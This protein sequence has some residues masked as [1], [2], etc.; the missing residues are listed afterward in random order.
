MMRS[1][2]L[3]NNLN[4]L[5]DEVRRVEEKV[6]LEYR[7][8]RST[9]DDEDDEH[10]WTL[11]EASVVDE[12]HTGPD[13]SRRCQSAVDLQRHIKAAT[14][15][16]PVSLL[17]LQLCAAAET[18]RKQDERVEGTSQEEGVVMLEEDNDEEEDGRWRCPPTPDTPLHCPLRTTDPKEWPDSSSG[19][20]AQTVVN[21]LIGIFGLNTF[22]VPMPEPQ[23]SVKQSF[24][25]DGRGGEPL[26]VSDSPKSVVT[27]WKEVSC[28]PFS[29]PRYTP[30]V[31]SQSSSR[32]GLSKPTG[33]AAVT[34][35][36]MPLSLVN[37][38]LPSSSSPGLF[39]PRSMSLTTKSSLYEALYGSSPSQELPRAEGSGMDRQSKTGQESF[40]STSPH[41]PHAIPRKASLK[42]ISSVENRSGS[43]SPPTLKRNVSF[44]QLE[45]REYSVA[46][47]DHPSCSFGP[48]VQL[49]WEYRDRA[50][51]SVDLYEAHRP[52]R[53]SAH[54][55]ILSYNV[56]RF[57]LLHRA[58][59]S[60]GEIRAAMQEVDR[61]KRNRLLTDLLLPA[62]AIDE[63]LE[64]VRLRLKQVFSG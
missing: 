44:H 60:T 17:H 12:E 22:S 46:I 63:T 5:L 8:N 27:A 36:Q 25:R 38:Q 45:I 14:P 56:R 59:Y 7:R 57:L 11:L 21:E 1:L 30:P 24:H 20:E 32:P 15:E 10:M 18:R 54:D 33:C 47:S 58:G 23:P 48:P 9:E 40:L 53:R 6:S 2:S 37:W 35:V 43:G 19:R 64:E 28:P 61:V 42:R 3:P 13:L 16:A 29:P 50:K 51:I 31:S 41:N 55:M 62:S 49:G 52:P 39:R 26:E 4:G 34:P